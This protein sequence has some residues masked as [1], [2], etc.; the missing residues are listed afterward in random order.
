MNTFLS[1][2]NTVGGGVVIGVLLDRYGFSMIGSAADNLWR[3]LWSDIKGL[4]SSTSSV[5]SPV[6]TTVVDPTI[7]E[8]TPETTPT[9]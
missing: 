6:V 2:A 3:K 9:R 4:W 1:F 5:V 8:V 7:R